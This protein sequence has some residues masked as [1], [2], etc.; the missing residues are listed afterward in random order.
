MYPY[1][2]FISYSHADREC[3]RV[4]ANILQQLGLVALWDKDLIAG[5]GF[6]DVIQRFIENC[7][8][9]MPFFSDS[10]ANRPWVNQEI[11]FAK[12]HRK[13]ILPV[14]IGPDPSGMIRGTHAVRLKRDLSDAES[15]LTSRRFRELWDSESR[16]APVYECAEDNLRRAKL[17]REYARDVSGISQYGVVRQMASLT[18]FHLP[19]SSPNHSV[20]RNYYPAISDGYSLFDSLREERESLLEHAREC[21]CRLI[22][23]PVERLPSV[24]SKFGPGNL[25][26]RL[27][28]MISFLRD[29]P[30][31]DVIVAIND[32]A[33]RNASLT[34][35]GDWFSAEAVPSGGTRVLREAL[36]T[37][38]LATIRLQIEDFDDR[39]Q[40]LLAQRGWDEST[41]REQAALYL[42]HYLDRQ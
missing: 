37:R 29:D 6:S 19:A 24:Y 2:V 38:D 25:R 41:S 32:D 34:I 20:W 40:H 14:T 13:P 1:R 27:E 33:E 23:D 4:I 39:L 15:N 30:I 5:T 9:F 31:E 17:L 42:Q 22:L 21:G 35:V 26:H 36:F 3:V 28:A 10:A 12:A 18:S 8:I 11:G 16:H 7:H